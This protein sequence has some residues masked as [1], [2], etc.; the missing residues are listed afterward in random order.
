MNTKPKSWSWLLLF[1]TSATLTCCALPILLV[2]VGLGAAVASMASAAPWLIT[3]SLYKG[4]VF[5]ASGVLIAISAWVVY[6]PGRSCPTDPELAAACDRADRWNKRF[7]VV[8]GAMWLVGFL[9]AYAL[10]LF[11]S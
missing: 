7:L 9:S 4:W 11:S 2:S 5:A 6:R 8:S 3:L 10:P 1:T